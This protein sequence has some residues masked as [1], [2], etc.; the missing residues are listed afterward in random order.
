M[1][2]SDHDFKAVSSDINIETT[3]SGSDIIDETDDQ[4]S[5]QVFKSYGMKH[6]SKVVNFSRVELNFLGDPF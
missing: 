3:V 6:E 1:S 4:I 5:Q 2:S